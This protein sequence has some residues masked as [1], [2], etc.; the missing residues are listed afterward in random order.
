MSAKE[1]PVTS[2][3]ILW[4]NGLNLGLTLSI[5]FMVIDKSASRNNMWETALSVGSERLDSKI[6]LVCRRLL[7]PYSVYCAK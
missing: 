3:C 6:R 7:P 5:V 1:S 4:E 2:D